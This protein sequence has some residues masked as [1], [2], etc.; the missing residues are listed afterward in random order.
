V[1][2]SS[3]PGLGPHGSA[4]TN[5]A[6]SLDARVVV[7]TG[8]DNQVTIWDP[9]RALSTEVLAA[10]AGEVRGAAV[11]ADGSTLYTSS[12]GGAGIVWDLSGNRVF[13]RRV[14]LGSAPLCCG[15][16]SPPAPPVALSPDGAALAAPVGA[17][18]VGLFSARTLRRLGSFRFGRNGTVIAALAWSP[19][20]SELG[21]AGHSG[22][23]E[24]WRVGSRPQLLRSLIGLAPLVGQPGAVQALA[25]SPDGRLL[26]ATDNNQT[27]QALASGVPQPAQFQ[28]HLARLA[29]WSPS[30]GKLL[31]PPIDLGTGPARTTFSRSHPTARFS[32]LAWL[33][34]SVQI[35]NAPNGKVRRVLHPLGTNDTVAL[36]F[37][38][39]G[40]LAIGT[41]E[42][43]VQLWNPNSGDQTA[44]P[45]AVAA[46]PVTSIAFDPSGHRFATTAAQDGTVKL[47]STSPLQQE[48][49]ALATEQGATATAAFEPNGAN[50]LVIDNHGNAF[51]W[52][53][54]LAAW[55]RRA[56]ATAGRNFTRQ[57]WARFVVGRSYTRVCP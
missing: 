37:S 56:C 32:P 20:G 36:A 5:L 45:M 8:G 35:L 12:P 46:G 30:T 18:T 38:R 28:D 15:P 7:A 47:W 26:A 52:P 1:T 39:D 57:E 51:T 16:V 31:V 23:V 50:L 17:G 53:M 10:P 22:L 55:E 19:T 25:F 44:G 21:V 2:G 3:R 42:G 11:S 41:Q 24:L 6:Y 14:R 27:I 29:I 49:T 9:R 34:G 40:T 13:G 4:V 48:G 54:S 43:I 33:D